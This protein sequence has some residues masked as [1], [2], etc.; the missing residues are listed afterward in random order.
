MATGDPWV[1]QKQREAQPVLSIAPP[2]QENSTTFYCAGEE[3]LRI[4]NV[5]F[6]VKGERVPAD[7]KEAEAVYEGFKQWLAWHQLT[8]E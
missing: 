5:G 2:D 4:S 6:F 8:R 1:F 3:V 7:A